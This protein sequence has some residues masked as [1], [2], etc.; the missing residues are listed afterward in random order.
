[1]NRA[2]AR[3]ASAR[4]GATVASFFVQT[5]MRPRAYGAFVAPSHT[6]SRTTSFANDTF[7]AA[8]RSYGAPSAI[9]FARSPVD[10]EGEGDVS[11]ALLLERIAGVFEREREIGCGGDL[12]RPCGGGRLQPNASVIIATPWIVRRPF[13]DSPRCHCRTPTKRRTPDVTSAARAVILQR[14]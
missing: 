8:K 13:I 10:S 9:C 7:A 11:A 3:S 5:T 6:P 2:S 4:G 1:L 14:S 12:H